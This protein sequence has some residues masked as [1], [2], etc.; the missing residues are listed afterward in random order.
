MCKNVCNS[1]VAVFSGPLKN[2]VR[3]IYIYAVSWLQRDFKIL[4]EVS[5][6]C[7]FCAG[8]GVNVDESIISIR[9]FMIY[10]TSKRGIF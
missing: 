6:S 7:L 8:S 4:G 3:D 1:Y 5:G 9:L 10:V 2:H